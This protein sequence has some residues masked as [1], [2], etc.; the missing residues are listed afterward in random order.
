V[1]TLGLGERDGLE[2]VG[3]AVSAVAVVAVVDLAGSSLPPWDGTSAWAPL[4]SQPDHLQRLV[5]G[6]P[7]GR[8]TI[9]FGSRE[10]EAIVAKAN[11]A[12]ASDKDEPYAVT[13]SLRTDRCCTRRP[14]RLRTVGTRST[15]CAD[16]SRRVTLP[17]MRVSRI[18]AGSCG[19]R[20]DER[21]FTVAALGA[22]ERSVRGAFARRS[23][24]SHGAIERI[25]LR[26]NGA[27]AR[28]DRSRTQGRIPRR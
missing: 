11:E 16:D 26:A 13:T 14:P 20:K 12:R 18:A 25:A 8:N 7:R 4:S 6:R 15:T 3:A 21:F 22:H 10:S 9:K 1:A 23:P 24:R 2:R 28:R 17:Q 5:K 19:A 27:F